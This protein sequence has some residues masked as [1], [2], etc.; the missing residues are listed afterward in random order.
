MI[1]IK[2]L[3]LVFDPN[4]LPIA[5][6]KSICN[7]CL[8]KTPK[9]IKKKLGKYYL[10]FADHR[11]K[12]IKLLYSD[13]L[14]RGWKYLD[15]KILHLKSKPKLDAY[16]HIASPEIYV[17][18]KEKQIYI[19]TH[20][21]SRSKIGQW[22]YL[23]NSKDGIN[24]SK[25]FNKPLAPFYLRFFY[26]K[27]Y[28]YGIVKG[29][30]LWRSRNINIKFQQCQNLLTRKKSKT[31]L[32][33][34]NGSIR[35]LGILKKKNYLHCVFSKIGDKPER[36]YYTKIHLS[37]NYLNWK[38]QKIKEILRPTFPYEGSKLKLKKSKAGD[39]P[40]GENAL[41][42]PYLFVDGKKTYLIYCVKGEKN[43][44]LCEIDQK[45]IK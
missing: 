28:Y 38:F 7:P 19:F 44:A 26:H 14:D 30:D 31:N 27:K 40:R 21:H 35:H 37:K 17:N 4:I 43:F 15:K 6:R 13:H 42:D 11:G 33:N 45:T 34:K 12:F 32:H 23:S 25:K 2:R 8:I 29:A 1:K 5:Q 10:Y 20:S 39:A 9:W 22:T 3:G 18:K 36:I 16:N 24:F 41:R